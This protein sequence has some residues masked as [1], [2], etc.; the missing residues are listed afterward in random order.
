MPC[1]EVQTY[2]F[3]GPFNGCSLRAINEPNFV[4]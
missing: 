2:H 4:E 3:G 1:G